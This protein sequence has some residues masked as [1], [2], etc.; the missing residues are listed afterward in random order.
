M[1]RT[2]VLWVVARFGLCYLI[3][4]WSGFL[5]GGCVSLLMNQH[6]TYLVNSATHV[7]G[8]R[9]YETNDESRN[10]WIVALLA[11]GEGW[12]NNHHK[13]MWSARHGLRWWQFDISYM[14][15]WTLQKLRLVSAVRVPRAGQLNDYGR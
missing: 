4:G 1:S 15:I 8:T 14:V 6:V 13:F 10:N 7:L 11:M 12:H 2:F 3:G 5:W 9:D